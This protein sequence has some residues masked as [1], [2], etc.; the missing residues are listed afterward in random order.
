MSQE[1]ALS[2]LLL[3]FV[4]LFT[5]GVPLAFSLLFSSVFVIALDPGL[6][7]GVLPQKLYSGMNNF[8]LLAIPGFMFAAL[9]MNRIGV[10]EDIVKL[11]DL[12]V[13]RVK[14]GLAH[15]NVVSS[16]LMGGVS[17]SSTADV[18]G[19][20]A[21]LIPAMKKKGYSPGFSAALTAASSSIGSIIPPSILM[22]IYGASANVSIG[23][24]FIAGYVPGVLVGLQQL[25]IAWYY[26]HKY[27][28]DAPSR[29]RI[30]GREK[31]RV[32]TRGLIP[33]SV[34]GVIIGGILTG[35]MT[36]TESA[37]VAS[38]YVVLVG[39]VVY[40]KMSLGMLMEVAVE[41]ALLTAV[42][43]LCV[44]TATLFGWL[45]SFYGILDVAGGLFETYSSSPTM[46]LFLATVLFLFLGTF[47]D[48][49]PAMLI[50]VPVLAAV[51]ATIG[52]D[53]LQLGILIIMALAIGKITPPYGI[54]LLLACT[55]AGI[56]LSRGL[57]WTMVFFGA[58]C[59]LL[60][61]MIFFPFLTLWFP[62]MIAP[63]LI[64]R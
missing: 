15:I 32:L 33:V 63:D 64:G 62:Q 34:I 23:A 38:V 55:I 56:P 44:G 24:L 43:M 7:L 6:D 37:A 30:P 61:A 49:A 3:S 48:P 1:L 17:G 51:A 39:I 11:S 20:G 12:L 21:I 19:I 4:V 2:V 5:I 40:R 8:L 46:F 27:G 25:V 35:V 22:V 18:A 13:G 59:L 36:A 42:V 9:M 60:V 52:A 29:E 41:T 10:T 14:G 45:M 47:M 28:V 53:P 26:A 58:F 57:G 16:M 54:S 50:F 31:V